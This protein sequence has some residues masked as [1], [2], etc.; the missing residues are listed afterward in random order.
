MSENLNDKRMAMA[1]SYEGVFRGAQGAEVLD[2][3][4]GTFFP[5]TPAELTPEG[6]L[7]RVAQQQVITHIH[8]QIQLSKQG[9]K[10]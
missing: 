4:T 6:A 9:V 1:H 5:S 3:L 7:I 8:N 2:H 10:Q